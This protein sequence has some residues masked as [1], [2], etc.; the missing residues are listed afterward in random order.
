MASRKRSAKAATAP[1][2]ILPGGVSG[3]F[4]WGCVGAIAFAL[5]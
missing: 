4:G 5:S 1:S 3:A 2:T